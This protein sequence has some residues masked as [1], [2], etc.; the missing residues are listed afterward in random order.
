VLARL[1]PLPRLPVLLRRPTRTDALPACRR[2]R[3]LGHAE[4]AQHGERERVEP[5][6][7]LRRRRRSRSAACRPSSRAARLR[8]EG[9]AAA[10]ELE[11]EDARPAAGWCAEEEREGGVGPV[12]GVV[13]VK[14]ARVVGGGAVLWDLHRLAGQLAGERARGGASG[15]QR[16]THLLDKVAAALGAD[17]TVCV[18]GEAV[19]LVLALVAEVAHG[20]VESK[21]ARGG[22]LSP[23]PSSTSARLFALLAR[24][25]LQGGIRC[26]GIALE[27]G[28]LAPRGWRPPSPPPA[29]LSSPEPAL[30]SSP[31]RAGMAMLSRPA[32]SSR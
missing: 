23:L 15:A 20:V 4:R 17:D 31:P 7:R 11:A 25:Q 5:A 6:E 18:G 30:T 8:D 24:A 16:R 12:G 14:V 10:G 2:R 29:R 21:R 1:L 22:P 28:R 3:W 19:A 26:S 13:R 9:A 32:T 27:Q